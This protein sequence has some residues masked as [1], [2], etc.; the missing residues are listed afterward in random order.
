V[1]IAIKSRGTTRIYLDFWSWPVQDIAC[2]TKL[3]S[4]LEVNSFGTTLLPERSKSLI[5]NYYVAFPGDFTVPNFWGAVEKSPQ[6]FFITARQ[7]YRK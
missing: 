1:K 4:K 6:A 2:D 7:H 3:P 5:N